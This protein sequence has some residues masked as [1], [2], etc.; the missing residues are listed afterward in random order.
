MRDQRRLAI[1]DILCVGAYIAQARVDEVAR[2]FGTDDHVGSG[3]E[4]PV[5]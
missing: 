2:R 4:Q 5:M 1:F 3:G